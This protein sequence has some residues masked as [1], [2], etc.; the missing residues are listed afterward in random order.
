MKTKL[1]D[2][3]NRDAIEEADELVRQ[4]AMLTVERDL[5]NA[6]FDKAVADIKAARD[7]QVDPLM[8]GIK[9]FEAK[10][11]AWI[12]EHPDRFEAPRKRVTVWG[13]YGMRAASRIDVDDDDRAI[14]WLRDNKMYEA[15]K[16][17]RKIDRKGLRKVLAG[18]ATVPGCRIADGEIATYEID[19]TFLARA[20]QEALSDD[21]QSA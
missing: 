9:H 13:S 20:K 12:L 8:L 2:N 1:A 19:K 16:I 11:T 4:L 7:D 5:V 3:R 18:G 14:A 21:R 17:T 6:E 15:L 10:L